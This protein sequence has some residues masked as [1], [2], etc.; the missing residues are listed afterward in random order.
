M[1]EVTMNDAMIAVRHPWDLSEKAMR[2]LER[3]AS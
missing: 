2:Y 1:I 3:G